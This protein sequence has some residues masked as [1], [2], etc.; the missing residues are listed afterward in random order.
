MRC[1]VPQVERSDGG[2]DGVGG[3]GVTDRGASQ[4][5]GHRDETRT[6]AVGVERTRWVQESCRRVAGGFGVGEM[7]KGNSADERHL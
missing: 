6:W 1:D 5:S 2:G 3:G 4:C 7:H